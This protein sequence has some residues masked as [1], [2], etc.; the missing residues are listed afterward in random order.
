MAPQNTPFAVTILPEGILD[1]YLFHLTR[2]HLYFLAVAHVSPPNSFTPSN[3]TYF[4]F[5]FQN[6]S[7]TPRRSPFPQVW[8]L[9]TSVYSG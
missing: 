2:T 7:E 1:R 4:R 5:R 8:L 6:S 3:F 9:A